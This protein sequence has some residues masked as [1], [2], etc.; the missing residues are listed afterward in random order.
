MKFFLP[1]LFSPFIPFFYFLSLNLS[2]SLH[3]SLSF[4]SRILLIANIDFCYEVF[5]SFPSLSLYPFLLPSYIL[6]L[7]LY[8]SLSFQSRI[9]LIANIDFSHEFFFP[10]P[11]LSFISFFFFFHSLSPVLTVFFYLPYKIQKNDQRINF[12]MLKNVFILNMFTLWLHLLFLKF[13]GLMLFS[14]IKEL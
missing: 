4:Q 11:S 6:S 1:F 10:F 7:C 13:L 2:L 14:P 3:F 5:S 8:F 12:F 9:L